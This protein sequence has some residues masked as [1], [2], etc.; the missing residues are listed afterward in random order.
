MAGAGRA[1]TAGAVL[2]VLALVGGCSAWAAP[3]AARPPAPVQES[4]PGCGAVGAF[5][6]AD[7]DAGV[8]PA[9]RGGVPDGFVPT[10]VV[11]CQE[12]ERRS[13]NGDTVSVDL[14]RTATGTGRLLTYLARAD[15]RPTD[16]ACPAIAIGPPWLF[17]LDASGR[18]VAPQV[19]L[20]ACGLP[21]G[22]SGEHLAWD[23]LSYT[24]RVVHEGDVVESAE[25]RRAGCSMSWKDVVG[26]YA[27][28]SHRR[29]GTFA[30]D[31]FGG[32]T[33]KVC[34]YEVPDAERGTD[35]APGDFV[36]GRTL[37]ERE[38]TQVVAALRKARE[39]PAGCGSPN[40]RF[41]TLT[42]TAGGPFVYVELDGCRRVVADGDETPVVRAGDE[43]V[44]L[45]GG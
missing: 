2:L 41:A 44:A 24:D 38:R 43:L 9:K 35:A 16:G 15:E 20:D 33:L 40:A 31:P 17:L 14:E 39:T 36:A 30:G 27:T 12:G 34:V 3:A 6:A 1:G 22:W 19:P 32:R 23:S 11:L 4:W 5:R 37:D 28:S 10:A 45:L 21:I 8:G 26:D 42:S 13:A 25:V 18:Y 7:G 29:A